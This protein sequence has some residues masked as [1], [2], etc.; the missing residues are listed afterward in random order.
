MTASQHADS[1]STEPVEDPGFR[2]TYANVISALEEVTARAGSG[3]F[4][5][6][7]YCGHG[8]RASPENEVSNRST[9]DLA[10]VLLDTINS[11]G[12]RCL[13]GP[14]L[15]FAVKAM[16]DKGVTVTMVLDCCFSAS[17]YRWHD[18]EIRFLPYSA[19]MD[20]GP[21]ADPEKYLESGSHTSEDRDVS[22]LPNW[23]IN[24]DGYTIIVACGP[25]EEAREP[26]FEGQRHGALTYCLLRT[27]NLCAGPTRKHRDIYSHLRATF[28]RFGLTSQNPVI[29][30]NT[31]LGFFGHTM[32]D[33]DFKYTPVIAYKNGGFEIQAGDAHGVSIGDQLALHPLSTA[34]PG[35]VSRE[36]LRAVR[37]S[38]TKAFTST[39]EQLDT[40]FVGAD[41]GWKARSMVCLGLRKWPFVLD[42]DL[43]YR[44]EWL[45][46]LHDRSLKVQLDSNDRPYSF[47]VTKRNYEYEILDD[48]HR[49]VHFLPPLPLH[50]TN[51]NQIYSVMEHLARYKQILELT[52]VAST[53]TFSK[54][55][56][57]YVNNQFGKNLEPGCWFQVGHDESLKLT[58]QF[59]NRGTRTL[60]VHIYNLGPRWEVSNIYR[61]TYEAVPPRND[62]EGLAGKTQKTLKLVVPPVLRQLQKLYCEDIVKVFITSEPTSFDSLELP[63]LEEALDRTTTYPVGLYRGSEAISEDWMTFNFSI[64]TYLR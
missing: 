16:V 8:T 61:A 2:P 17:V 44:D 20:S 6:I 58:F 21:Q 45:Q 9:G 52:N 62:A 34:Q 35:S 24:P 39:A 40:T 53:Y 41:N 37:I 25:N 48:S 38:S 46:V 55:F 54:S 3:D 64:R 60:Y 50:D 31:D 56:K 15:A 11:G 13:W 23:L 10:L 7:H 27:L 12:T 59:E 19:H 57:V 43:P 1:N 26:R 29:Y 30:G 63:R 5:Y 51:S 22:M 14:R 33:V 32:P 42:R 49:R 28:R 4:V 36:N 47:V 18:P